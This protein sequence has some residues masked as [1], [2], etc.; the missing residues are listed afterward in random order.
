MARVVDDPEDYLRDRINEVM[1]GS[2]QEASRRIVDR[3]PVGETGDAQAGWTLDNERADFASGE[4]A[5]LSN[6]VPYIEQL[7]A[8]SS[9]QAPAGAVELTGAEWPSIAE[10]EAR[11]VRD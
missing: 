9:K 7:E 3:T 1:R 2:V 4:T 10:A 11:K 6:D 8:G 5:S